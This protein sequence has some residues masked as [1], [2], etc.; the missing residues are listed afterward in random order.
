MTGTFD[1]RADAFQNLASVHVR[2]GKIEDD[3]VDGTQRCDLQGFLAGRGVLDDIAIK[4]EARTQKA[5][6]LHFIVDDKDDGSIVVSHESDVLQALVFDI[7]SGS[8]ATGRRMDTHDPLPSPALVM[9]RRPALA[10]TNDFA[11]HKP[12]PAPVMID[13]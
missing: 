6:D 8:R 4:F 11:I 12:S 13:V 9:S 3:E 7:S 10:A 2:Q 1:Q 5:A